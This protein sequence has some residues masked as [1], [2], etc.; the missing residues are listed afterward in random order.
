MV[1][2]DGRMTAPRNLL[3]T[4]ALVAGTALFAISDL[5]VRGLWPPVVALVVILFTRRALVGLLLGAFAGA[6]L[7]TGGDPWQ[8]YLALRD[9]TG[10]CG[11]ALEHAVRPLF[12]R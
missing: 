3:A 5:P 4:V 8:A 12:D 11:I 10:G 7:L 2:H 9:A 1:W 6:A